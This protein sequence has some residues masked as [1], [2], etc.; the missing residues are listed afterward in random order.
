MQAFIRFGY[1]PYYQALKDH[2]GKTVFAIFT[3]PVA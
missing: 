1:E 3:D 2:F